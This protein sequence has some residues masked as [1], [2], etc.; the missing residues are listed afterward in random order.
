MFCEKK[1]DKHKKYKLQRYK[2]FWKELI[3]CIPLIRHGPHRRKKS[4]G[5]T[6]TAR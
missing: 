3:A 2:N 4:G 1:F 6:Q 5:D